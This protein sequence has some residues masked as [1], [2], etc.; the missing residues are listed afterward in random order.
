VIG[1]LLAPLVVMGGGE[2]VMEESPTPDTHHLTPITHHP[3]YAAVM[4]R[5]RATP[6]SLKTASP[7]YH[8]E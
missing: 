6:S 2:W 4:P 5:S 3:R 7:A 8:L 1:S